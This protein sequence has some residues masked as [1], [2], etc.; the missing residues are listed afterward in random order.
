LTATRRFLGRLY[1]PSILFAGVAGWLVWSGLKA[2]T[3]SLAATLSSGWSE[4]AG[5]PVVVVVLAVVLC[6]QMWPAE[7]RRP[8]ARGHL[9][10]ACFFLLYFTTVVPLVTLTGVGFATLVQT[11][12][13]W[14]HISITQK[15]PRWAL[16]LST[17]VVIDACNWLAHWGEHRYRVLWRMHAV[18]HTQE[19]LS[20]LTSFRAHPLVHTTGFMLATVPAI[21]LTAN[22][23]LAPIVISIYLCLGMLQH[24][25]VRW[26]YGAFGRVFVSPAYH[27]LHHS[28][29]G[30]Q[31]VNLGIV[32]TIWDVF[33]RR[34][35]FPTP[36]GSVC[37][38][39]LAGRPIAVEQATPRYQPLRTIAAQLVEPFTTPNSRSQHPL[40]SAAVR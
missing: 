15:W 3:G 28:V 20:V 39:G 4:L 5:P 18:H 37:R 31:D 17:L 6:E 24:A 19:E 23:P 14:V 29:D 40:A 30:P 12:A 10:D 38:T 33:A 21:A 36:G 9:Q 26:S 25:N 2:V 11:R 16:V 27:R 8:I 32:L 22:R 13:P 34:A 35:V 1:L 7:R